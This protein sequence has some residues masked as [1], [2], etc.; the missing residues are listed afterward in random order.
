MISPAFRFRLERI[1]ALRERREDEAKLQLAGAMARRHEC[2]QQ[3]SA[4]ADCL[5]SARNSQL[6]AGSS[7]A[8]DLRARQAY[9][10]RVESSHRS[11]LNDL[12]RSERDVAGRRSELTNAARERQ[13]LEHLKARR[14]AD[15][16]RE[17]ARL[18][19]VALDEIAINGFRRRTTT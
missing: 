7:S 5:L 16:Q 2:A 17:T 15:F 13:A 14:L 9:L 10:E 19:A 4:A 6:A 3:T 18:D 12:K 8:T 1:R 11:T